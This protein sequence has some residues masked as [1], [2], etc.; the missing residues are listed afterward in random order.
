LQVS[1]LFSGLRSEIFDRFCVNVMV[2]RSPSVL[3]SA[4]CPWRHTSVC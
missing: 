2:N 1:A 3:H 4:R